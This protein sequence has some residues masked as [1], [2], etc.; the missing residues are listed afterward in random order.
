M[1]ECGDRSKYPERIYNF[2]SLPL[3]LTEKAQPS[4]SVGRKEALEAGA[5]LV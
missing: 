3:G 5:V 1:N 4:Q 2:D